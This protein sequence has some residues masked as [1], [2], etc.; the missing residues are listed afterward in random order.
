MTRNRKKAGQGYTTEDWVQHHHRIVERMKKSENRESDRISQKKVDNDENST[1]N[2]EQDRGLHDDN[3]H[4]ATGEST[5]WN[6][7]SNGV[8]S[9]QFGKVLQVQAHKVE[10]EQKLNEITDFLQ[11]TGTRQSTGNRETDEVAS[12]TSTSSVEVLD[13]DLDCTTC[14]AVANDSKK[15]PT[16]DITE[17]GSNANGTVRT[18]VNNSYVSHHHG[19]DSDVLKQQNSQNLQSI[20]QQNAMI[21]S[22]LASVKIKREM[23]DNVMAVDENETADYDM[24]VDVPLDLTQT[25]VNLSRSGSPDVVMGETKESNDFDRHGDETNVDVTSDIAPYKSDEEF[26]ASEEDEWDDS[27][28]DQLE[29]Q[30]IND[31]GVVKRKSDDL[32]QCNNH[33]R[34]QVMKDTPRTTRHKHGQPDFGSTSDWETNVSNEEKTSRTNPHP[35]TVI[36]DFTAIKNST[37]SNA[38]NT[39]NSTIQQSQTTHNFPQ[40]ESDHKW[41]TISKKLKESNKLASE[42]TT[43]YAQ[44]RENLNRYK[45]LR[46]AKFNKVIRTSTKA[47]TNATDLLER[48][49]TMVEE[50]ENIVTPIKIEFNVNAHLNE[51]N[52]IQA[53]TELF[54]RMSLIDQSIRILCTT[55][56]TKVLWD[57]HSH[58]PEDQ[59]FQQAFQMREQQFRKGTTKVTIYCIVDSAFPIKRIKFTNPFRSFLTEENIWIKTDYYSTKVVSSPGFFT[60]K[61]P[62]ITNKGDFVQQVTGSLN[63]IVIDRQ[64]KVVQEWYS[65]YGSTETE[66]STLV[67]KF[68]VETNL[69][70]WG[71]NQAEVLSVHCSSEDAQ[72]MKY[73]LVEAGSQGKLDTGLF[74][75]SG[76]HLLE[77]KEALHNLLVEQV[78]FIRRVTSVQLDGIA[79]EEMFHQNKDLVTIKDI[80]LQGPGVKAIEK[81]HQTQYKGQWLVVVQKDNVSSLLQYITK[82]LSSLYKNKV[83]QRPKL[84]TYQTDQHTVGHKLVLM[85]NHMRKVGTYTD[86]LMR[87]FRTND[88]SKSRKLNTVNQYNHREQTNGDESQSNGI[89]DAKE[90]EKEVEDRPRG[91]T[92]SPRKTAQDG[93]VSRSGYTCSQ[94]DDK[95]QVEGEQLKK[96]HGDLQQERKHI[97]QLREDVSKTIDTQSA[98]KQQ[99]DTKVKEIE[100]SIQESLDAMESKNQTMFA[101]L[102]KKTGR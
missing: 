33:K 72:Y 75:P 62:R 96:I 41:E 35:E 60:L 45:K 24:E 64:E 30:F 76:I 80:L 87:K 4:N 89:N 12:H 77:G 15:A 3:S 74:V 101:D 68:H 58:L 91:K 85:E 49:R 54:R 9:V 86:I 19:K 95:Q 36:G 14:K 88:E 5:V 27:V 1:V 53:S 99:I 82:N 8:E 67:P 31:T 98:Y 10:K 79:Y 26:D 11:R 44:S 6:N 20:L 48:G 90:L 65:K 100:T 2:P 23:I 18:H 29:N 40:S 69:R 78:D 70:K 39:I 93:L 22:T 51:F 50:K 42:K 61:H 32:P 83:G 34:L 13:N 71:K 55:D 52:V 97:S 59:D 81:T 73:L 66:Q 63:S 56:D 94:L 17:V 38:D 16:D 102:K 84:I 37:Q 46:F 25:T 47:R 28:E 92:T 7:K 21:Q 57:I 43:S